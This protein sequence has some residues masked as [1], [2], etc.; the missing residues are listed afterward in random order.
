MDKLHITATLA[1]SVM[2]LSYFWGILEK[3]VNIKTIWLPDDNFEIFKSLNYHTNQ[4]YWEIFGL[5]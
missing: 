2:I 4:I 5:P 1:H 3:S